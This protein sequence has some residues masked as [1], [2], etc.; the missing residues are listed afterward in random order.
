M[1]KILALV[2]AAVMVLGM[3]V[4]ALAAPGDVVRVNNAPISS[5]TVKQNGTLTIKITDLDVDWDGGTTVGLSGDLAKFTA[6]SG[7]RLTNDSRGDYQNYRYFT[8]TSKIS[9]NGKEL[10]ITLAAASTVPIGSAYKFGVEFKLTGSAGAASTPL[11][12]LVDVEGTF[13]SGD[14]AIGNKATQGKV[15]K[16]RDGYSLYY[17]YTPTGSATGYTARTG[18]Y[19]QIDLDEVYPA[20]EQ[21]EKMFLLSSMFEWN[22]DGARYNNTTDDYYLTS[23]IVRNS[24]V[25][26]RTQVAAGSKAIDKTSIDYDN[27]RAYVLVE[28]V[29]EWVSV[30]ELDFEFTTYLLIDGKRRDT[31]GEGLVFYGTLKNHVIYV[32]SNDDYVDTSLGEVAH[33]QD[34]VSS[35]EVDLGAGVSIFTKF[36]KDKKYYGTATRDA[37][38]A[39]DV[40]FAKYPDVDNVV[41]LKTVGLNS[42]GDIVKLDTD[43]SDYYVYDKDLNYLGQSNSRLPFSSR[44]YLANRKLDVDSTDEYEEPGE[45][46]EWT[47]NADTGGDDGLSNANANPGTGC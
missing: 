41:I 18:R 13:V 31:D 30:D 39:A 35:I 47:D 17:G 5:D 33:A 3:G 21:E 42:T 25:S 37:D 6:V 10:L 16:F 28:F 29:D 27:G 32:Y 45:E 20:D 11:T 2:L 43:Y 38:E 36:F 24:K 14:E 7:L 8:P 23:Q 34:F 19:E 4:T 40:V 15:T 22:S 9:S 46:P 26:A 1:K 44:Y 12:V